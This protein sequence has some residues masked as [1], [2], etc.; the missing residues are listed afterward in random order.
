MR[1]PADWA[2]PSSERC[3]CGSICE[4]REV[5]DDVD[6]GFVSFPSDFSTTPEGGDR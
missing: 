4:W 6:G 2:C 3:L 1:L 5:V